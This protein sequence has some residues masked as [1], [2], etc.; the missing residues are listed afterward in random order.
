[1]TFESMTLPLLVLLALPLTVLGAT[2][3]LVLAGMPAGVMALV[4]GVALI[5]L[6]INPAILLVDRM[7]QRARAGGLS[8]G[9]AA[10]A[11]V[12]ERARPILMTVST[13]VAGLWPL[14]L[15]TGRENEIWPPFAMVVMGGLVTSTLLTLLVIPVGFVFLHRLDRTFGRLGPWIVIGWIAGTALVTAPLIASGVVASLTWQALTTLLVA[16]LLL[17]MAVW[18]FR[19]R[20]AAQP[21][22]GG[23]P[24]VVHIR[25]LHKIYNVPG[26]IGRAWRAPQRFARRVLSAGGRAFDPRDAR[27]RLVPIALVL[28]GA[29]YLA[30]SLQSIGWR[31]AFMFACSA[32][33]TA[34]LME[35]RRARGRADAVGL[36]EPGG[37]EGWLAFLA[38]WGALAW[39]TREFLLLPRLHPGAP[40]MGAWVPVVVAVALGVGQF[41]RR[42]ARR[43]AAGRLA[44]TVLEGR[45]R[46]LRTLWRRTSRSVFGLDLPREQVHAVRGVHISATGGMVGILGPNGAGKTTLLRLLAGILEPTLGNVTL[47]GVSVRRLRRYLARFIGFLPQEFGLPQDLTAREYLDYYALLYEIGPAAGRRERIDRLLT[48]VGLR[49][50]ADEP[51]GG[52]SGGMRQR[53]AVA[54]TLLRLPPVI[55]VDEP[56]VGLDPTERIR[57][58]NLL[59]RLARGR[60][61]FFST[62]VA[63]DVEVACDRVIVMARGRVVYDGPTADL[64]ALAEGRVWVASFAADEKPSLTAAARVVDVL[65][66]ASGRVQ[67]RILSEARPHPDAAPERPTLQDG[68][69]WLTGPAGGVA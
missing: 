27:E 15:V 46:L 5:G 69:L 28:A 10:L 64:A 60:I 4:G 59:A 13:A 17:G 35:L 14:A 26:P 19:P 1:V 6:T 18:L 62:H 11:A 8:A 45:M 57:F 2:W 41:G 44:E 37:L 63:E 21:E 56:T 61:V 23:G 40:R 43:I 58:R 20:D 36:V 53:V 9:A 67:T 55:I 24:P 48:E 3:A 39:A 49:D 16:S 51:I 31:M 29:V 68:Y 38:P 7:Q 33:V 52:Y 12:R 34:F 66:Q 47:G 50:R 54:R 32:L 25:Y 30:T 22:E 65:P 42:T